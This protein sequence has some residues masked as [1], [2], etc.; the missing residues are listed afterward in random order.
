MK[1]SE[2]K[3]ELAKRGQST[4]GLKAVFLEHLKEALGKHLPVLTEAD[5]S[6]C[7][8]D[9]LKGFAATAWWKP[10]VPQ[11]FAVPEP[12][13]IVRTLHAPT[14]SRHDVA[15]LPQKHNFA[16]VFDC[17][18][19]VAK[20]K[21]AWFHQNGHAMLNNGQTVWTEHFTNEGGPKAEFLLENG[22]N[23][24]S[25]P[26]DWLMAFL[27]LYNGTARC[28]DRENNV[29]F[30]HKWAKFTNMKAVQMGAGVQGG[31]YP[32]FIPF[33]YNE[34]EHFIGLYILQGLNPS[35]Q[36][37]INFPVNKPILCRDQ[38][39]ATGFLGTMQ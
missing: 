32:S 3:E 37:E 17:E 33:T 25:T 15:F 21:V 29:C 8:N 23:V 16:E 12:E 38:I 11:E 9:D 34:I 28:P 10:L 30:S 22:L 36:V 5:Q 18:P 1:V 20:E 14:V 35:P 27:P 24:N 6:A 19:F 26:Q 2:L 4:Q 7:T 39:F 31:C 13:N